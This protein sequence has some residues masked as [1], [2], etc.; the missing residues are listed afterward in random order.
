MTIRTDSSVL[1][2]TGQG[3]RMNTVQHVGVLLEVAFLANGVQ[4]KFC[5]PHCLNRELGVRDLGHGLVTFY[6]GDLFL[7]VNSCAEFTPIDKKRKLLAAWKGFDHGFVRVTTQ[8]GIVRNFLGRWGC[9]RGTSRKHD[10][11]RYRKY[12]TDGQNQQPA[13]RSQDWGGSSH[14]SSPISP[15]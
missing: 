9:S 3:G 10:Q 6:T 12:Q 8:A 15:I 13:I 5:S 1:V 4:L 14:Q 11:Y 7:S 2:A